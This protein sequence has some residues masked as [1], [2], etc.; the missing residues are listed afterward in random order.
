MTASGEFLMEH[1][2]HKIIRHAMINPSKSPFDG[3]WA[4]WSERMGKEPTISPRVAKLMKKQEGKCGRCELFLTSRD[5]VEVH[6]IDGNHKNNKETNLTLLHRH[7][8]DQAHGK[9]AA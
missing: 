2:D 7:C 6:H 3:D 9:V 4:D 5:L 8:H 1:T